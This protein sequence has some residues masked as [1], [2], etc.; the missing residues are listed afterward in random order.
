L[1]TPNY[2]PKEVSR[3]SLSKE[4]IQALEGHITPWHPEHE[5]LFRRPS[6]RGDDGQRDKGLRIVS[7]SS[8]GFAKRRLIGVNKSIDITGIHPAPRSR[9]Q[10]FSLH[11]W[12]QSKSPTLGCSP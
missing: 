1:T 9:A 4:T 8:F 2:S 12:V 3:L 5:L 6:I 7:P 11:A 10:K